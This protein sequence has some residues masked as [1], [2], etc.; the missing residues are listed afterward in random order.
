MLFPVCW[1]NN[2]SLTLRASDCCCCCISHTISVLVVV[3]DVRVYTHIYVLYIAMG[4]I[5]RRNI[6]TQTP[7]IVNISRSGGKFQNSP[8]G[9]SVAPDAV[10]KYTQG[11]RASTGVNFRMQNLS[12]TSS[13]SATSYIRCVIWNRK[14]GSLQE[15]T[16]PRV[17][18]YLWA[19]VVH[20]I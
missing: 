17:R 9:F 8:S 7:G 11:E 5:D 13:L 14:I 18:L 10:R 20:T 1:C 6:I 12:I 16:L 19:A 4:A 15:N 3:N 2:V